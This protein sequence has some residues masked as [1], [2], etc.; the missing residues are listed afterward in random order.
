VVELQRDGI[1][2]AGDHPSAMPPPCEVLTATVDITGMTPDEAAMRV[3]AA[4]Q[5]DRA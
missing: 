5:E 3:L 1:R 2:Y 4:A